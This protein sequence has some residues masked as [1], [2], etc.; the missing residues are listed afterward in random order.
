MGSSV[1]SV[2]IILGAGSCFKEYLHNMAYFNKFKKNSVNEKFVPPTS[3]TNTI[4]A[5]FRKHW[6][7]F[8]LLSNLVYL[9]LFSLKKKQLGVSIK[10]KIYVRINARNVLLLIVA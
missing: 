10:Y 3:L 1:T 2:N 7:M 9:R 4:V 5:W 6:L 8:K